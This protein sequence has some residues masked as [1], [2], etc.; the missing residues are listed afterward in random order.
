VKEALERRE[1]TIEKIWI[2]D[3]ASGLE[4]DAIRR[5]ASG[6]SVPLQ[7]VPE[8]RFKRLGAEGNH[9][10]VVAMVAPV[11]FW[12]VDA[13]MQH[14]AGT[15]DEVEQKKPILLAL[16]RI[17]D[18]QNFG[19]ILRSALAAGVGGVVVPLKHMAPLNEAAI[20]A[21]AGAALQIP[22]ARVHQLRDVL[23]QLKERGYWVIGA[24]SGGETTFST[25]DWNR[26]VV[27][28]M[29][30]ERDGI[31]PRLKEE[32]DALVSIPM[33]GP[34]ESLNVSVATALILFAAR[35]ARQD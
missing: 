30:S 13:L 11:A 32:C 21:S 8:V 23:Y 16:D 20:K 22:V 27:I 14:I 3:R 25:C 1:P 2:H 28:V 26:P 12:D 15:R 33:Y 7:F 31:H 5:E 6:Q 35:T 4:I 24:D 29:G 10:G 17:E 19:A 18:P 34:V 9:Q